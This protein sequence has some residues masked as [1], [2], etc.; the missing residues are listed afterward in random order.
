MKHENFDVEQ[1]EA[2]D[3]DTKKIGVHPGLSNAKYHG[4]KEEVSKSSLDVIR[5]SPAHFL[6]SRTV[7]RKAPTAA[8]RT[9]T[10]D[11]TILLEPEN[12]W[13]EYARPFVAPVGA[14]AT[15]DDIKARLKELGLPVSGAKAAI[16][17]RL[18][19]ADPD[20]IFLDDAKAAYADEVGG[21]EILTEEE[22]AQAEA[23]RASV[24]AHPVAGKLLDP[25][26]GIAEL[27]C[28]WKD[29]ETGV[30]CRCRPD[31]WRR[32]GLIVD[33]KTCL[34]ASPEGFSKSIYNWRYHVQHA[35]YVDGIKA[36]LEQGPN[37]LN[38]PAPTHFV[39]VAVEK[40]APY[41][42]GVY[43]L[44]AESVDIGRRDYREDLARYAEC[45]TADDW[46]AYSPQIEPISLPEWVLRRES[47]E[48]EEG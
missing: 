44:D 13:K 35:F 15:A 26:A 28:Y 1:C 19:E 38:M 25:E 9:G 42:V 47:Y 12:F 29:P 17:D 41:A 43:M 46:P 14:L 5:K 48:A 36:A 6:H 32:D 11:H 27:S 34:D 24:M 31:F 3:P 40:T 39:F 33:L 7:E 10:I 22:L 45:L 20:A 21:R 30:Q 23:V 8:Q 37:P 16:T 18:R 4:G 2:V